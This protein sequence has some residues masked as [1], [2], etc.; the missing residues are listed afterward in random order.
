MSSAKKLDANRRNA[1]ASTG[2]RTPEGKTAV[3]AN[4]VTHGLRAKKSVLYFESPFDFQQLC[5]DLY[6]EW[7]PATPTEANLVEQMAIAQFKLARL[8]ANLSGSFYQSKLMLVTACEDG[9]KAENGAIR[10]PDVISAH[11]QKAHSLINGLSQHIARVERAWFNA[12]QMLERFQERREKRALRKPDSA[13][14][15]MDSSV[16]SNRSE[17]PSMDRVA[18]ASQQQPAIAAVTP[19]QIPARAIAAVASLQMA[20]ARPAA[21]CLLPGSIKNDK[22][23]HRCGESSTASEGRAAAANGLRII[24]AAP[25]S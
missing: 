23:S 15:H 6:H 7:Q 18:A 12:M 4:A 17:P 19:Q 20:G 24:E 11:E 1:L 25:P 5:T 3:A 10:P 9:Y 22:Q 16:S 13:E 8:E 14:T 21:T 2:P